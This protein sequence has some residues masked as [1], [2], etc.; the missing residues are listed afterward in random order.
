[1]NIFKV[2]IILGGVTANAGVDASKS[3]IAAKANID[4]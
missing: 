1:M 3:T 2:S 4:Y